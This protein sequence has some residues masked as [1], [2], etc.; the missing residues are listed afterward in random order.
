M[1]RLFVRLPLLAG[2]GLLAAW[3]F[4]R[5][6]KDVVLSFDL[7]K[8]LPLDARR[9]ELSLWHHGALVRKTE[10]SLPKGAPSTFE[11][12]L[13][14]SPGEYDIGFLIDYR[15]EHPA[16]RMHGAARVGVAG[17]DTPVALAE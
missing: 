14:L 9:L 6:P 10:L 5:S 1:K 17:G 12:P 11:Y 2:V 4:W 7:T 15:G 8:L 16:V 3:M 13:R